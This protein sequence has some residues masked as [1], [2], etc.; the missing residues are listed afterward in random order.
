MNKHLWTQRLRGAMPTL[1]PTEYI[2]LTIL[3]TYSNRTGHGAR[4]AAATLAA[5]CGVSVKTVRRALD[6]LVDKTYLEVEQEGGGRN[7]PTVYAL[8]WD[9]PHNDD[10]GGHPDDHVLPVD[11][12]GKVDTQMT[13]FNP[14]DNSIPGHPDDHLSDPTSRETWSNQAL[15]VVTQM[16]T[17]QVDQEI[18]GGYVSR[19]LTSARATEQ[20]TPPVTRGSL[21]LVVSAAPDADAEP[22]TKCPRHRTRIGRIDEPCAPCRDARLAHQAW[23]EHRAQLEQ[24]ARDHRRTAIADCDRCDDLGWMLDPTTG[25]SADPARR[26]THQE[27][28]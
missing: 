28:R 11:N 22:P 1:T 4:P 16:T 18:H 21:A 10:K 25:V 15:N 24:L 5:D 23:T 19:E 27:P 6:A 8:V 17:D 3:A 12:S 2:V 20:P 14:V 26:C 9:M 7:R 13:M